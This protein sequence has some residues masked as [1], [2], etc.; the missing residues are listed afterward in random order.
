MSLVADE[1]FR[2]T[3][4]DYLN[5]ENSQLK[6]A[7]ST[8]STAI[9]LHDRLFVANVGDSR[10]VAS[11]SGSGEF[12]FVY[13]DDTSLSSSSYLLKIYD[14]LSQENFMYR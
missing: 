8:A 14:L 4:T 9:L 10:V 11:K 5:E 1:A 12:V 2:Q 6:N 13:Y 3:D 7:G